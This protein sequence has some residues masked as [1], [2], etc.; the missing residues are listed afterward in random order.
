MKKERVIRMNE[1]AIRMNERVI[2]MKK[3]VISNCVEARRFLQ[4]LKVQ[5]LPVT[6]CEVF[7]MYS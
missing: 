3:R 5:G 4:S 7:R 1:R 2:R 6:P